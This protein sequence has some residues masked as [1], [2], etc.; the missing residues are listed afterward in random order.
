[1]TDL[2]SDFNYRPKLVSRVAD[3]LESCQT[4]LLHD[5]QRLNS[6]YCGISVQYEHAM[7]V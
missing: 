6:T 2:D 1:M 3:A 5:I 7:S 4:A